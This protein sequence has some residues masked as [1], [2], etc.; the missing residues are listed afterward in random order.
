MRI[1]WLE[2]KAL[3][4]LFFCSVV[5]CLSCFACVLFIAVASARQFLNSSPAIN[6]FGPFFV[7]LVA[8]TGP[9]AL[10]LSCGMAIFCAFKDRSPVGVKVL[11]F[12]LFLVF[13]PIGSMLYYFTV[14]R[15]HIKSAIAG[16]KMK[17]TAPARI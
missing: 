1:N 13:W 12:L 10:I 2:S 16:S 8:L 17:S 6:F 9:G 5:V 11:R 4:K 15:G 14:Y 7:A 3:S